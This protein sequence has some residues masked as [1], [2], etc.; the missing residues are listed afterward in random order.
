MTSTSLIR[1]LLVEDSPLVRKG[2]RAA[3]MGDSSARNIEVVGEAATAATALTEAERLEPDV[4]LLDL[5]LPDG[6]GYG[7]CARLRQLRPGIR[8]LALTSATDNQSIYHSIVSGVHGYLFKEIDPAQLVQAIIDVHEGRP[9]FAGDVASR[10]IDIVREQSIR[11]RASGELA[12]LSPQELRVLA[13][14]AAGH[15]NKE[16]SDQLGL[17]ENTVKNYVAN[18]FQKLGVARRSQAAAIYLRNRP[19]QAR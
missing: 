8:I 5:R 19:D 7:I 17:S 9:V 2:I 13:A 1:V 6:N 10:V 18:M 11:S 3:I 14:V 16:I 12:G 15:S 4:V